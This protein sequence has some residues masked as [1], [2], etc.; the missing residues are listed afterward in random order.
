MGGKEL[1]IKAT[2]GDWWE[3]SMAA[4]SRM[5]TNALNV[6]LIAITTKS[7]FVDD[8]YDRTR[9]QLLHMCRLPSETWS[10]GIWWIIT[11]HPI[12]SLNTSFLGGGT[13][14]EPVRADRGFVPKAF[15]KVT[16]GIK[17]NNKKL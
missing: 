10:L 1:K 13:A 8:Y 7:F 14:L 4:I 2:D 11:W 17:A 3:I 9:K 12:K 5:L 6:T 15:K 16:D